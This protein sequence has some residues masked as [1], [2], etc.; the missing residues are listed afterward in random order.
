MFGAATPS[1]MTF[2]TDGRPEAIALFIAGSNC[3]GAVTCTPWPPKA[4]ATRS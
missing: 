2:T 3:S 1:I 4:S